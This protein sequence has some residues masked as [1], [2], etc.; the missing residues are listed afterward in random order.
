MSVIKLIIGLFLL[1]LLLVQCGDSVTNSRKELLIF[2]A[3][4][5]SVPLKELSDAFMRNNPE[6]TINHEAAGSITSI[7][8]ITDL[9][10]ECDILIS[11]DYKL[12]DELLIPQYASYNILFSSNDIVLIYN[13]RSKYNDII[14]AD[15][16]YEILLKDNVLF[17]RSDPD[18]DP[19]GYRT[20]I[21]A[22]IAER[23]YNSSGLSDSLLNKD[24]EYIRPKASDLLALLEVNAVDYIFEY[25]S[26]AEQHKLQYIEFSDSI[27]LSSPLLEEWYRNFSTEISGQ[28]PGD[29]IILQGEPIVYGLTIIKQSRNHKIAE[30]FIRFM[31]SEDE[32]REILNENYHR[33]LDPLIIHN[34][35]KLSEALKGL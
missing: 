1:S 32:G 3:G 20:E 12:I 17:G 31:L 25:K 2:H 27:N 7:R 28:K 29:K 33:L 35:E 5:V 24:H 8:K 11:A 18:S 23:F 14:N 9:Q 6:V 21:C 19:C 30:S 10:R 22:R 13:D 15:N 26:V 16:W 4:S 34:P